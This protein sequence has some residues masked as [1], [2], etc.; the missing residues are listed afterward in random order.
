MTDVLVCCLFVDVLLMCSYDGSYSRINKLSGYSEYDESFW[1]VWFTFDVL[2]ADTCHSGEQETGPP[3]PEGRGQG[4]GQVGPCGGGSCDLCL[5][6]HWSPPTPVSLISLH[7]ICQGMLF[8]HAVYAAYQIRPLFNL[9]LRKFDS[10]CCSFS[11]SGE[12]ESLETTDWFLSFGLVL[13]SQRLSVW[14]P[15]SQDL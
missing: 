8:M 5:K 2:L 10:L 15:I 1:P 4:Q 11:L 9:T 14:F 6:A 12:K 3:T 7:G 13:C